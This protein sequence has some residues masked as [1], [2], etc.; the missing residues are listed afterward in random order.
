MQVGRSFCFMDHSH[1]ARDLQVASQQAEVW[2]TVWVAG[3]NSV[4]K[5]RCL[6]VSW[7]A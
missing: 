1:E 3:G 5:F 7:V 6:S 2:M 4:A